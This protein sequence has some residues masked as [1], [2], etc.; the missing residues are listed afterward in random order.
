MR[1]IN[2]IAGL[3]LLLFV[4]FAVFAKEIPS[5][6]SPERLVNDFA[7]VLSNEERN[8]LEAKLVKYNDT[9]STQ[10]TVVIENS[11]D[12]DDVFD[13]SFRLAQNWGIGQKGKNN[14]ILIYV[15]VI[16]RKIR[17]QVGYGLEATVTDA[18]AKKIIEE[19]I[20]PQFKQGNYYQGI[21]D[22]SDYIIGLATGQYKTE[23]AAK[24]GKGLLGL[25]FFGI[26]IILV[27]ISRFKNNNS[28][29]GGK[30]GSG[31][32]WWTAA[33]LGSALS[34]GRGRSYGDFSSGGGSFGGF[35][36]GSFGGGGSGGDW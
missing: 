3:L 9:T 1:F 34:G 33:L 15:A 7:G 10:I 6:P 35:G 31:M 16:D 20:K 27:I 14:G 11:L 29:F 4:S 24:K 22:A 19:V 12:G 13:Y 8:A 30:S 5:K 36:G 32:T 26:I 2:K 21:S 25:I 28:N 18:A 17:I 23:P